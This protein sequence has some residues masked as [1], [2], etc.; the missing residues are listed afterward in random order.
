VPRE[1]FASRASIEGLTWSIDGKVVVV[2]LPQANQWLFVRPRGT[3][4]I[5]PVDR[6]RALFRGGRAPRTGA[7]PRPAGWCYAEPRSPDE[8]RIPCSSGAAPAP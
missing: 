5:E 4:E 6:V 8:P 3:G 1:P 2:G 7:F